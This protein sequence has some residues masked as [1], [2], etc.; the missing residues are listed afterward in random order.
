MRIFNSIGKAAKFTFVSMPLSILGVNHLKMGNEQI[1]DLYRSLNAP[2]C[3]ECQRGGLH[4]HADEEKDGDT[5]YAWQCS[6]KDCDFSILGPADVNAVRQI[7]TARSAERG[8][9]RLAFLDDPERG[10]LIRA[11]LRSSRFLWACAAVLIAGFIYMLASGASV[12]LSL[13]WLAF[14]IMTS[15]FALKRSYRA[16]QVET[17]T[18]FVE[19]AFFRFVQHG[20]WVR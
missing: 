6:N 5:L 13:N 16:W 20:K 19:G 14:G 11:H 10:R 8:R 9:Q 7:A 1:R 17:G 4:R 3:P 15:V 18:I 2:A 12:M